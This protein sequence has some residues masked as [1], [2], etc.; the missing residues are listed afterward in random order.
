MRRALLAPLLVLPLL[1]ALPG[2]APAQPSGASPAP[3]PGQAPQ[4]GG[5]GATVRGRTPVARA[6]EQLREGISAD[7][8]GESRRETRNVPPPG[9]PLTSQFADDR[10]VNQ[11]TVGRPEAEGRLPSD[12]PRSSLGVG[13]PQN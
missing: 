13:S 5:D 12:L 6:A 1:G 8:A 7:R 2:A 3:V 11:P 9:A 10:Q 4:P